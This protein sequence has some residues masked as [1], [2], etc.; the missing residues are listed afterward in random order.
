LPVASTGLGCP[1]LDQDIRNR[2]AALIH[3]LAVD[4]DP[5]ADRLTILRIVQDELVIEGAEF[6]VAEHRSRHFRQRV[7]QREQWLPGR[8]QP[9]R[10]VLWSQGRRMNAQVALEKLSLP[11]HA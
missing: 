3:H 4:D 9:A 8:A 5:L 6:A 11:I 10:L 2:T 7:L 1:K